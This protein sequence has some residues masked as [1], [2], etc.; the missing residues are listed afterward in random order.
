MNVDASTAIASNDR[1]LVK[2]FPRP[3][4]TSG[5][6]ILAGDAS[7]KPNMGVVLSVPE[8]TRDEPSLLDSVQV[9]DGVMWPNEYVAD[10]VQDGDEPIV[11]LKVRNIVAK[12]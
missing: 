11:S 9:G 4:T 12:W 3:E 6:L 7:T 8:K 10:V 2:V 5:G 1:I